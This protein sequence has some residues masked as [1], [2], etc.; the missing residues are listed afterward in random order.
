MV[1]SSP[2]HYGWRTMADGDG[3]SIFGASH[4]WIDHNSLSNCADGLIDAIMGSTAITISNNYFTHHN[5]V[6]Y[7]FYPSILVFF[8]LLLLLYELITVWND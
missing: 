1:R 7:A 6:N 8:F 3:I 5:E 4:I 2:S